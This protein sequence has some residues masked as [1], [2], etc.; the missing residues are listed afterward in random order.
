MLDTRRRRTSSFENCERKDKIRNLRAKNIYSIWLCW[1][2]PLGMCSKGKKKTACALL[3]RGLA[4]IVFLSVGCS[5]Q[6]QPTAV[7]VPKSASTPLEVRVEGAPVAPGDSLLTGSTQSCVVEK[8]LKGEKE[9]LGTQSALTGSTES[10]VV[11]AACELIYQGRFDD[12]G[13]LIKQSNADGQG[14]LGQL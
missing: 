13:E 5:K 14:Q 6:A 12:A 10:I 7:E 9:R 8:D 3:L 1:L 11:K 2:A 4:A